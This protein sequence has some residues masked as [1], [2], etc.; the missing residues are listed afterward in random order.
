MGPVAIPVT[1]QASSGDVIV[2]ILS[3]ADGNV[4]A[5]LSG[6]QT[7]LDKVRNVIFTAN[8]EQRIYINV[9]A[10]VAPGRHE[11][12]ALAIANSSV[13][14]NS[15]VTVM[16]TTP[17]QITY[18]VERIVEAN[19]PVQMS[20]ADVT[21]LDGVPAFDPPSVKFKGP[22]SVLDQ[23]TADRQ[24]VAYANLR[25]NDE[26]K[27]PGT[28][29]VK[30]VPLILPTT[31]SDVVFSPAAVTVTFKVR[32]TEE[33]FIYPSMPVWVLAP[34]VLADRGYKV[35]ILSSPNLANVT[36]AGSP[37]VI[38][39]L[40]SNT[41]LPKPQAHLQVSL[42]DLTAAGSKITRQV[43]YDLPDGVHVTP[44]DAVRT[45]DFRLVD[46]GSTGAR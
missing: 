29:E 19:L 26:L 28:H 24:M 40:R 12:S 15:G 6:P 31:D 23:L 25:G 46:V 39:Q 27:L 14:T 20:A 44:D 41:L 42:E 45:V 30:S 17:G 9:D 22:Q 5:E 18:S 33:R 32:Q 21:N 11:I 7:A 10:N 37:D 43:K 36:L 38:A 13:F 4:M 34:P 3:P 1:L 35:Q 8:A 2:H 16:N